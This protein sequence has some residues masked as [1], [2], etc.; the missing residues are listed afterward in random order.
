MSEKLQMQEQAAPTHPV[1]KDKKL[2]HAIEYGSTFVRQNQ[3]PPKEVFDVFLAYVKPEKQEE[4]LHAYN[5][6]EEQDNCIRRLKALYQGG[7]VQF[8]RAG[9]LE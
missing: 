6:P 5:T 3:L 9:L 2:L 4:L 7:I 1:Y 8:I